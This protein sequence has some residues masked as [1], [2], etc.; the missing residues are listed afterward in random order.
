MNRQ[1]PRLGLGQTLPLHR[2]DDH[3]ADPEARLAGADE[4]DTLSAQWLSREAP[5]PGSMPGVT[6]AVQQAKGT[7][8]VEVLELQ[9]GVRK[10]RPCGGDELLEERVV[11]AAGEPG[12]P[13]AEIQSVVADRATPSSR[14]RALAPC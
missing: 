1:P 6:I 14:A 12:T 5:W 7:H 3:G 13:I 9:D 11:C 10:H 4:E 8:V 2:G